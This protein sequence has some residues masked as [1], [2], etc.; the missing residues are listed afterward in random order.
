MITNKSSDLKI[1]RET[2]L[3]NFFLKNGLKIIRWYYK[4]KTK[5]EFIELKN[6][7]RNFG[8]IIEFPEGEKIAE[9]FLKSQIMLLETTTSMKRK[10]FKCFYDKNFVLKWYC[11]LKAKEEILELVVF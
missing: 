9:L 2:L 8:L 3:N 10:I 4:L 7:N 11:K 5:R 6:K 1:E